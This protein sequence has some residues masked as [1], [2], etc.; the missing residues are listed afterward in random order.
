LNQTKA[1]IKLC[2]KEAQ[3]RSLKSAFYSHLIQRASI[4]LLSSLPPS[5]VIG[6][7]STQ[8]AGKNILSAAIR[9]VK[10]PKAEEYA[11]TCDKEKNWRFKYNKHLMNMV[12]LSA[13]RSEKYS[14]DIFLILF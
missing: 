13:L 4:A 10:S 12:K 5:F 3:K 11:V 2:P 8:I 6:G 14:E 7:R 9:G 1:P